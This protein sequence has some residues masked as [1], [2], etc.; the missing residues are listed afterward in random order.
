MKQQIVS[1]FDT[2]RVLFEFEFPPGIE[3]G[4]ATRYALERVVE[5]KQDL[6]GADLSDANLRDANLRDAN[7]RGASLSGADL[8][9]ADLSGFKVDLF[10]VLMRAPNEIAGLRSALVEGRVDGS[11]YSGECA[12]LVGTIA[13]VRQASYGSLGNGLEPDGGR[14]IEQW[15]TNISKGDTPATNQCSK[16][17]VEWLDEFVGLLSAMRRE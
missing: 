10:D 8:S 15:F 7:L 16:L 3:S 5:Q 12:C 11:T 17:A 9:G 13:N 6:S 4:I 2:N 1:R 14:P